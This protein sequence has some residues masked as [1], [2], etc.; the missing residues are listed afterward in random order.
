MMIFK[1][2]KEVSFTHILIT[3]LLNENKHIQDILPY[4]LSFYL[5][6][7]A[8]PFRTVSSGLFQSETTNERLPFKAAV[9][10]LFP[11]DYYLY[12]HFN[13]IS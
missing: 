5:K 12:N 7:K 6:P 11:I 1:V 9:H 8:L 4:G 10:I 2:T 3:L 13:L